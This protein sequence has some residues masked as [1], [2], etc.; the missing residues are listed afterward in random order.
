MGLFSSNRELWERHL[1]WLGADQGARSEFLRTARWDSPEEL[2]AVWARLW[3]LDPRIPDNDRFWNETQGNIEALRDIGHGDLR[4]NLRAPAIALSALRS[5][6]AKG[7]DCIFLTG[8][9][10]PSPTEAIFYIGHRFRFVNFK[11][12]E[13]VL[14][15]WQIKVLC[16]GAIYR[17]RAGFYVSA[18]KTSRDYGVPKDFPGRALMSALQQREWMKGEVAYLLEV[19]SSHIHEMAGR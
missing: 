18:R 8:A 16:E 15:C 11:P 13:Q 9:Q 14:G 7:L 2:K 4:N 1:E 17:T 5:V 6:A 12:Q 3:R 19:A 10:V